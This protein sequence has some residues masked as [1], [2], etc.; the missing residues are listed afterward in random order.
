MMAGLTL[1]LLTPGY[2]KPS[3]LSREKTFFHPFNQAV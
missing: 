3:P 2:V 1:L